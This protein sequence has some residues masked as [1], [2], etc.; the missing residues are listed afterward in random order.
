MIKAL[1]IVC[2]ALAVLHL[3]SSSAPAG[4]PNMPGGSVPPSVPVPPGGI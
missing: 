3:S 1:M 4:G 2:M